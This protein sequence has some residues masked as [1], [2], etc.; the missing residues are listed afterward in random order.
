MRI[1]V[2]GATG[3]V[4]TPLVPRLL[5]RADTVR[6]LVR[7][8]DQ[9]E[10]YQAR[11]AEVALGDLTQPASLEH[12][13]AEVDAIVHLA[14]FFRGATPAQAETVNHRGLV[15]LALAA[16]DLGIKRFI[17]TSTNLV[18]G[19]GRGRPTREDDEPHPPPENYYAA[20]KL[21]GEHDLQALALEQGLPLCI[22]RLAFVYGEGDPHLAEAVPWARGCHPAKKFHMVHHADV[23]QAV[24]L[25][26]DSP[27]AVGKLYNVAD[28]Q[29]MTAREVLELNGLTVVPGA[30]NQP[31]TDAWEGIMDTG[32]I[33]A[34]LGFR[35]IY[36][37]VYDA[38]YSGAL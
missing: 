28:D 24:M 9:A 8:P 2:T 38:A 23:A 16:Q 17:Y 13:V 31:L 19:Y 36:P 21:A 26:L 7:R 5:E 6:V 37:S 11:G 4:G 33:R 1:L 22:L 29:P 25:A 32:C 12:A 34:E 27:M 3:R 18:Y 20:T 14:A 35:P 15:T 30:E 10:S